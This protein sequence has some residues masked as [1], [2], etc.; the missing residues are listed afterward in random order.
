MNAALVFRRLIAEPL[1]S[2][3]TGHFEPAS[4]GDVSHRKTGPP[5]RLSPCEIPW[6]LNAHLIVKGIWGKADLNGLTGSNAFEQVVEDGFRS[7]DACY[8]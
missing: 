1:R 8:R 2:L 6:S 4:A 7:V 3:W 5:K